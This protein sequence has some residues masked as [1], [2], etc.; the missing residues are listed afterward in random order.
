VCFDKASILI[1]LTGMHPR[2]DFITRREPEYSDA[3]VKADCI[4]GFATG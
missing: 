2:G 4:I 3:A 1:Q